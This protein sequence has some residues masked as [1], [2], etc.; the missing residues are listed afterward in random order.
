MII[1]KTSFKTLCARVAWLA[2]F[3]L[4]GGVALAQDSNLVAGGSLALEFGSTDRIRYQPADGSAA[5]VVAIADLRNF[6]NSPRDACKLALGPYPDGQDDSL[7][8]LSALGTGTLGFN[9]QKD[10]IGIREQKRGVDCGR[11]V[12]GQGIV[13]GV[14]SAPELQ[15]LKVIRSDLGFTVKKSA[16]LTIVAAAGGRET[17]RFEVRSGTAVVQNEGS[18]PAGVSGWNQQPGTEHIFNCNPSSDSGPDVDAT[19]AIPALE[20]VWDTL[21]LRTKQGNLGEWSLGAATSTFQLAQ[22]AGVLTCRETTIVAFDADSDGMAQLRRLDNID[23]S[24]CVAIPYSLSFGGQTVSFLADYL[25]QD[26]SVAFEWTVRWAPEALARP[27][28]AAAIVSIPVTTQQFRSVDPTF[29]NDLCVGTPQYDADG[30]LTGVTAPVSGFPDMSADQVVDGVVQVT[31]LPGVQYGCVLNR[32]IDYLGELDG[33][34]QYERIQ[35][36]E[37]GYLQGDWLNSRNF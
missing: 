20:A 21:T 9:A 2:L 25:G 26:E 8:S 14:G 13:I 29:P 34:P 18:A 31:G 22:V 3:G 37:S 15:G 12:D 7:L 19:C 36:E 1:G 33:N 10:W 6:T 23:G 27:V 32:T 28:D 35:L 17:A 30:V 16:A 24:A 4:H 5:Q 11:F